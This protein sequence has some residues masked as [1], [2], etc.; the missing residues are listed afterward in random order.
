MY[1]KSRT[2]TGCLTCYCCPAVSCA[3]LL[4]CSGQ[5]P[6]P[7][8]PGFAVDAE[9]GSAAG[10]V[11]ERGSH[12]G[13]HHRYV[14][15][16]RCL[17]GPRDTGSRTRAGHKPARLRAHLVPATVTEASA[18]AML[19]DLQTSNHDHSSHRNRIASQDVGRRT[20]TCGH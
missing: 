11:V 4:L 7:E 6:G 2:S 3:E 16:T 15:M 17:H 18:L 19:E 12:S 13:D 8:E 5:F 10:N 9:G 14:M 1:K 20:N